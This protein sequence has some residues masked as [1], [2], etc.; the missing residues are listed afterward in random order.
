MLGYPTISEKV[1]EALR[2]PA[3]PS[4][5]EKIDQERIEDVNHV[6]NFAGEAQTPIPI[7][8]L[9]RQVQR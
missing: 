7:G 2:P 8:Q 9:S 1:Q 5:D 3:P 6:K 4:Y